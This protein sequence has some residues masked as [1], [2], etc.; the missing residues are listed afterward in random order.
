MESY[1]VYNTRYFFLENK[2]CNMFFID[3]KFFYVS[4]LERAPLVDKTQTLILQMFLIAP[5][6]FCV[7]SV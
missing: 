7:P 4:F 3:Q 2:N 1:F 6:R 5:A